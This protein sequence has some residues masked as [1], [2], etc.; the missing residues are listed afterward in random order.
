MRRGRDLLG[1]L[2]EKLDIPREALPHGFALALSGGREMTVWGCRRIL[3]YDE[4]EIVVLVQGRALR[5]KGERLFCSAFG[6][7]A[8]TVTGKIDTLL[9]GEKA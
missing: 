5:I 4:A 7:G 1:A 9:L 2:G 6:E 3:S 8:V